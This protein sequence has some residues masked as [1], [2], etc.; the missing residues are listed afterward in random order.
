MN[1]FEAEKLAL[2]LME[3]HNL[4]KQGWQFS[5]NKRKNAAGICW[6]F[7]RRIELSLPLTL[8]SNV[9]DVTDTILHEIAH[10][11]AGPAAG[12]G[13]T[14]RRIALSI[15]CNGKRCYGNDKSSLS[16]AY[17]TIAKYKGVCPNGH[18][19]F[20]NRLP[21]GKRSCAKCCPKYDERF[22]IKYSLNM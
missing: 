18:E 4:L 16:Q 19:S 3:K 17:K 9:E 10:A 11:L 8:L 15:G 13:P 2:Q 14:W 7:K 5:F 1:K 20:R 21:R 12:H 6:F 22:L